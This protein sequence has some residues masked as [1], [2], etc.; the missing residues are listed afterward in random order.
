L[1]IVFGEREIEEGIVLLRS[2]TSREEEKVARSDLVKVL[3]E[4]LAV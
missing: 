1:G 3:K 2:I 4:K